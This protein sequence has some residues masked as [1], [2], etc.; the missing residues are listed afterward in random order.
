MRLLTSSPD[1]PFK[2][3]HGS[4]LSHPLHSGVPTVGRLA[5]AATTTCVADTVG[6]PT[7]TPRPSCRMA[8]EP[9]CDDHKVWPSPGHGVLPRQFGSRW[10]DAPEEER[11]TLAPRKV[12]R[13]SQCVRAK[14]RVR[15]GQGGEPH[16]W[17]RELPFGGVTYW[18]VTQQFWRERERILGAYL[19]GDASRRCPGFRSFLEQSPAQVL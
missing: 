4:I 13:V 15:T 17:A 11:E 1:G 18:F 16:V 14:R 6:P 9:P 2:S 5:S 7:D 19:S 10:E 8:H 3:P 12:E